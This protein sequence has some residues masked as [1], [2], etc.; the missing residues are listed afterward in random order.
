MAMI[1][2]LGYSPFGMSMPYT[3]YPWTLPTYAPMPYAGMP[4]YW[5][6]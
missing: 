5:W 6:W 1:L 4:Y 3:Y 2:P